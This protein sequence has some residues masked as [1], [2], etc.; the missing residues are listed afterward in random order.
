MNT[1]NLRQVGRIG[2]LLILLAGAAAASDASAHAVQTSGKHT[3]AEIKKAC[4][5]VNGVP[6]S[7]EGGKGYGCF[8]QNKNTMVACSKDGDCTGFVPD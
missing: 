2:A 4:D 1:I 7:G 5:D 8:N 3:Q 6:V